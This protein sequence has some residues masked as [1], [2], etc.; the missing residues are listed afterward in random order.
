MRD[1]FFWGPRR[2]DQYCCHGE[3]DLLLRCFYFAAFHAVLEMRSNNATGGGKKSISQSFQLLPGA[4][5]WRAFWDII[6]SLLSDHERTHAHSRGGW[7]CSWKDGATLSICKSWPL[8]WIMKLIFFLQMTFTS[9]SA[10]RYSLSH[11]FFP[12]TGA[13]LCIECRWTPSCSPVWGSGPFRLA[14]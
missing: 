10:A 14:V 4:M 11:L 13:K 12:K 1:G 5:M 7:H 8:E 2:V 3:A 6:R 9:G